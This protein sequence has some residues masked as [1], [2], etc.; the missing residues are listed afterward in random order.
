MLRRSFLLATWAFVLIPF[1]EGAYALAALSFVYGF[2]LCV[3][4]PLTL[5]LAYNNASGERTGEVVGIRE[6]VNQI[7]RVLA[8]VV[9]GAIGTLAGVLSVFVVGGGLL[10]WGALMLRSGNLSSPADAPQAGEAAAAKG[11][12]G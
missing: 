4:Q 7:T 1:V 5:I 8:P 6:S 9:F 2:G 3:G 11:P 10:A 12:T